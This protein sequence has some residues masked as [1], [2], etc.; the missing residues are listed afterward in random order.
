MTVRASA[1][2]RFGFRPALLLRAVLQPPKRLSRAAG[3][4]GHAHTEDP[5]P[6][7]LGSASLARGAHVQNEV[8]AAAEV[9]DEQATAVRPRVRVKSRGGLGRRPRG[10]PWKGVV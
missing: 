8:G 2:A 3:R 1:H 4:A 9:V 7:A 6:L 5:A 10:A